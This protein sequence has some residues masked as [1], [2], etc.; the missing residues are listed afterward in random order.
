MSREEMI[1]FANVST[2]LLSQVLDFNVSGYIKLLPQI[3]QFVLDENM[4]SYLQNT[5]ELLYPGTTLNTLQRFAK[6]SPRSSF[7]EEDYGSTLVQRESNI[8]VMAYWPSCSATLPQEDRYLPLS[9]GQ[10]QFFSKAQLG[11]Q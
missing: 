5:Y 8:V 4:L 9:I 10:A 3:K 2:P 1:K 7:L 6:Q 11:W